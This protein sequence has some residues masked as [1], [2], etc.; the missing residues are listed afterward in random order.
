MCTCLLIRLWDAKRFTTENVEPIAL[1][2]N[3][4]E[5]F[6]EM[7]L[8]TIYVFLIYASKMSNNPI[9]KRLVSWSTNKNQFKSFQWNELSFF[10]LFFF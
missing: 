4:F 1:F 3:R 6:A 10:S 8:L 7:N 9:I 5:L 2:V